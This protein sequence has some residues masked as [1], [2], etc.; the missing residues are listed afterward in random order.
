MT[1]R[2]DRKT[3]D[4]VLWCNKCLGRESFPGSTFFHGIVRWVKANGW[5]YREFG[6]AWEHTCPK[7]DRARVAAKLDRIV[8]RD[9]LHA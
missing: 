9:R 8:D 2:R 3:K 4:W 6:G 1:I 7:C 5:Q